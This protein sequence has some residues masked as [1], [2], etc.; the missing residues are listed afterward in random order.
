[1]RRPVNRAPQ[2]AIDGALRAIRRAE[3]RASEVFPGPAAPTLR[4]NADAERRRRNRDGPPLQPS[5]P[6]RRPSRH[7]LVQHRTPYR[8]LGL[9]P[10]GRCVSRGSARPSFADRARVLLLSG[11]PAIQ[12]ERSLTV[13]SEGWGLYAEQLAEEMGLYSGTESL[14]GAVSA[15]LM[16]AARLVVDTGLHALGWSRSEAL[17]FFTAHVPMPPGFLAS[18]IDRYIA[19]P[20]QALAYLTGKRE[21]LRLRAQAIGQLGHAFSLP[22][23]HAAVLDQ[24]SLPMPVLERA[25]TDWVS[26]AALPALIKLH[27]SNE[28]CSSVDPGTWRLDP[29]AARAGYA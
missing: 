7:L 4:C 21:I 22:D 24:G 8:R 5:P 1:M 9:G 17:E 2:T 11:L 3:A 15:S 13:F 26:Q 14:I 10:R 25:I 29:L 27:D 20:G 18:E 23:F 12:R 19:M 6:G 28:S 16:R